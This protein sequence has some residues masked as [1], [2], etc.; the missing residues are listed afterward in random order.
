M[1]L[2]VVGWRSL[3]WRVVRWEVGGWRLEVGGLWGG[4]CKV[5]RGRFGG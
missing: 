3:E 1:R 5:V 2:K 4:G